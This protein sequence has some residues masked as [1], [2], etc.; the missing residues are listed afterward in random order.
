MSTS[1]QQ[2]CGRGAARTQLPQAA[3]APVLHEDLG[4]ELAPQ[5][6]HVAL[7]VRGERPVMVQELGCRAVV[8][9]LE[10][11]LRVVIQGIDLLRPN[12]ELLKSVMGLVKW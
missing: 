6:A 1:V 12:A 4:G 8:P 5:R 2:N 7:V 11:E 3:R 10:L 9:A